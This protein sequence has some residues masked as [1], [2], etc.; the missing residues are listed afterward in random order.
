MC[1]Y[2]TSLSTWISMLRRITVPLSSKPSHRRV[3]LQRLT[4][5]F[6]V[7]TE[8][9][10]WGRTR[11][12]DCDHARGFPILDERWGHVKDLCYIQHL[13][14]S[15]S[16]LQAE[17]FRI[18]TAGAPRFDCTLALALQLRKIIEMSQWEMKLRSSCNRFKWSYCCTNLRQTDHWAKHGASV[19][20][21]LQL[22]KP[23]CLIKTYLRPL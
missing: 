18:N 2:S 11:K 15:G 22:T 7:P 1:C 5:Q 3:A 6:A 10:R 12:K 23:L 17:S 8:T 19:P 16:V 9:Y 13:C 21:C 20:C 14:P 4:I